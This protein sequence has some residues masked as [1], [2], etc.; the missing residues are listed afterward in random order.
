MKNLIKK[1]TGFF[2]RTAIKYH[3]KNKNYEL[4]EN[5][6]EATDQKKYLLKIYQEKNLLLLAS[7]FFT[8]KY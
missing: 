1:T 8:H 4:A 3:I 5:L 7:D 2:D 6:A